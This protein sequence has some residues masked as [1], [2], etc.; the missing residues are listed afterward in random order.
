MLLNVNCIMIIG[1][2][3][4]LFKVSCVFVDVDVNIYINYS[5]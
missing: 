2:F 3:I 4:V 5:L 1:N